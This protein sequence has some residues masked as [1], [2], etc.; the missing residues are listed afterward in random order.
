[1]KRLKMNFNLNQIKIQTP[2]LN[3]FA[4]FA[5]LIYFIWTDLFISSTQILLIKTNFKKKKKITNMF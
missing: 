1:M 2:H 3:K 4:N 5:K